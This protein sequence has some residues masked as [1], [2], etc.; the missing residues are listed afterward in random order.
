MFRGI[1]RRY[2]KLNLMACCILKSQILGFRLRTLE[3]VEVATDGKT[4]A[5]PRIVQVD[6]QEAQAMGWK[7]FPSHRSETRR[8]RL[9]FRRDTKNTHKTSGQFILISFSLF[10]RNW[11]PYFI[12]P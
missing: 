7:V 6:S 5:E 11:D 10:S 4:T 1:R 2:I 9:K 12:P 3:K 8:N